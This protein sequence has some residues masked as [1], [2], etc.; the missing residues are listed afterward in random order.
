MKRWVSILLRKEAS[1]TKQGEKEMTAL[2]HIAG[3]KGYK[4][5]AEVLLSWEAAADIG[6]EDKRTPLDIAYEK[7][8]DNMTAL[9]IQFTS[10]AM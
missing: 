3:K 10:P 6:D 4:S 5:V 9:L 8:F 7:G 1:L 2:H